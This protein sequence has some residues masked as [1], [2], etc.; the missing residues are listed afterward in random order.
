M[1]SRFEMIESMRPRFIWLSGLE[2]SRVIAQI[3]GV[4][5]LK[6]YVLKN[7]KI[8]KGFN[9]EVQERVNKDIEI[10][11][12]ELE[13]M[14]ID[15]EEVEVDYLEPF[16]FFTRL[17]ELVAE[18]RLAN[19]EA[20]IYICVN[21]GTSILHVIV[22]IIAQLFEDVYIIYAYGEQYYANPKEGPPYEKVTGVW[23]IELLPPFAFTY[24]MIG[25][26]FNDVD[27]A[28][29][30]V[31]S[32]RGPLGPRRQQVKEKVSEEA[33]SRGVSI[34]KE[35]LMER[36]F[37]LGLADRELFKDEKRKR[38][39]ATRI[40]QSLGKLERFGL[41]KRRGRT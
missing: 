38:G 8:I 7:T 23:K 9:D 28:V 41:I 20:P 39:L 40:G 18:E 11:K 25:K 1:R 33:P 12:K 29:L 21:G 15:V 35:E 5:P 30:I 34:T 17:L 27:R 22:G 10:L 3:K 13:E 14:K 36:I 32:E 24:E 6:V 16:N 26:V 31:L 2:Y 4:G 37:E 19:P